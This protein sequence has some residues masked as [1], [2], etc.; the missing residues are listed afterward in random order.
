MRE[1]IREIRHG[2]SMTQEEFAERIGAKQSQI[3]AFERGHRPPSREQVAKIA[4][5]APVAKAELY[6]QYIEGGEG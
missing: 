2:L 6:R 3:S 4:S 1:L 5:L